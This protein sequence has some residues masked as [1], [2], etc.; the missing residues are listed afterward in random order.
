[1]VYIHLHQIVSIGIVLGT[2]MPTGRKTLQVRST[3]HF[4]WNVVKATCKTDYEWALGELKKTSTEATDDFEGRGTNA[5]CKALVNSFT[6]TD[7]VDNSVSET[8]NSYILKCR[9]KVLIGMLEDIRTMIM[10]RIYDLSSSMEK[11]LHSSDPLCPNVRKKSNKLQGKIRLCDVRPAVGGKFEVHMYD[12]THVVCLIDRE[13]TCR[14]WELTGIPCCHA[15]SCIFHNRDDPVKF[16]D[17]FYYKN[18]TIECYKH[19][20]S[21]LRGFKSWP[22]VDEVPIFPTKYSRS[23][24]RP[25]KRRIRGLDDQQT[26][27]KAKWSMRGLR[28]SCKKCDKFDHNKRTCKEPP[29]APSASEAENEPQE[30]VPRGRQPRA[31]PASMMTV[32]KSTNITSVVLQ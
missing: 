21:P 25:K 15:L 32:P 28:M 14:A 17:H 13:C 30:T 24:G 27:A 31:P 19:G 8:F 2:Y 16:I 22:K 20:L 12:D 4:F 3:R 1:M 29:R 26:T 5:F 23:A 11:L 9:D 18:N 6:K 10:T 7:V